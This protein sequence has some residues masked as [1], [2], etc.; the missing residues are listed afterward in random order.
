[1]KEKITESLKLHIPESMLRD[2]QD[3]SLRED[4]AV[5]EWIR[6]I[7][8]IHLYGVISNGSLRGEEGRNGRD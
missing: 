8:S 1:M 2:I 3:A 7:L 6:H 5:S 4:R